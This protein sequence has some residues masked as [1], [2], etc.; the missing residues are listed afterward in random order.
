MRRRLVAAR[1]ILRQ[2][3]TVRGVTTVLLGDVVALLALLAS[4]SN[5]GANVGGLASHVVLLLFD[6]RAALEWRC[7]EPCVA[8]E[9][10]EPS[11]SRL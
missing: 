1:A 3:E 7:N 6:P 5:L 2:F 4:Q 9:G 10:L 11:T 8:G